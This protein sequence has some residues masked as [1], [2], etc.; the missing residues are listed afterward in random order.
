MSIKHRGKYKL[1]SEQERRVLK[2]RQS[3][4]PIIGYLKSDNRMKR[5]HLNGEEGDA[6]HAVL[7]AARYNICWLLMMIRIKGICLYLSIVKALS[8]GAFLANYS[9]TKTYRSDRKCLMDRTHG[10]K[11]N[12]SRMINEYI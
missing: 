4:Q 10:L 9:S 2:R 1:L 11:M 12:F 8:L 5:C 7:Y 6:I 3:V